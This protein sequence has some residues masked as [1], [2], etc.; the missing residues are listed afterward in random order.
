[1][2]ATCKTHTVAQSGGLHC[3]TGGYCYN[4][5]TPEELRDRYRRTAYCSSSFCLERESLAQGIS[6]SARPF[7]CEGGAALEYMARD[8]SQKNPRCPLCTRSFPDHPKLG[9]CHAA[10]DTCL[11]G[12]VCYPTLIS[13]E[14]RS[15]RFL[16]P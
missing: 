11:G 9:E 10:V 14:N 3:N 1:S 6:V 12:R 15:W 8:T 4:C 13:R 7:Q 5:A 2:I 16:F